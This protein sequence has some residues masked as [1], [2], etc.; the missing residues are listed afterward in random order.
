MKRIKTTVVAV[1]LGAATLTT[2]YASDSI[3]THNGDRGYSA[4]IG[5]SYNQGSDRDVY[6]NRPVVR[7]GTVL[8]DGTVLRGGPVVR[9]GYYNEP[10]VIYGGGPTYLRQLLEHGF[11]GDEYVGRRYQDHSDNRFS[12]K[13]HSRHRNNYYGYGDYG[14][15]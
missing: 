5:R 9:G 4:Q 6:F 10:E 7:G 14:R 12:R 11:I 2:A 8:R 15:R 3:R 13:H 1:V